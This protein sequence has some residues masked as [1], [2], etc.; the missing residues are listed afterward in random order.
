MEISLSKK[1]KWNKIPKPPLKGGAFFTR[2][3]VNNS[4]SPCLSVDKLDDHQTGKIG[5]WAGNNSGGD[6]A[7]LI[8]TNT[9]K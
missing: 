1:Q 7:N 9:N 4:P 6:F 2:V 3:Y 8:I 5:L